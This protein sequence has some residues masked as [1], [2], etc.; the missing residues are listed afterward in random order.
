MSFYVKPFAKVYPL[1]F[2]IMIALSTLTS[3]GNIADYT[4]NPNATQPDPSSYYDNDYYYDGMIRSYGNKPSGK[5]YTVINPNAIESDDNS[6]VVYV[7]VVVK[8]PQVQ[9]QY[10]YNNYN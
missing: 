3:C 2:F 10:T 6:S 5:G 7:P 9:K 8:K 4:S 1:A